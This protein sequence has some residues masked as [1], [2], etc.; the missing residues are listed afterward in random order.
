MRDKKG[1]TLKKKIVQLDY[2]QLLD[3]EFKKHNC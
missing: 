1:T 3:I 2:I